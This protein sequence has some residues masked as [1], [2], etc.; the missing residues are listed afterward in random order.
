MISRL[1]DALN[2]IG[3]NPDGEEIADILWLALQMRISEPDRVHQD[4]VNQPDSQEA[5]S[6]DNL[7]SDSEIV[8]PQPQFPKRTPAPVKKTT[9]SAPLYTN[10][11]GAEQGSLTFKTPSAPSLQEPLQLGKALRPLMR[12]V[13]S[14]TETV[15]DE[16]ATAERI[17]EEKILVPVLKPARERWLDLALIADESPSMGIWRR[18]VFE[19]QR[20]LERHGAFR[21]VQ[22]WGLLTTEKGQIRLRSGIGAAARSRRLHSPNELVDPIGQRLFL[23]VSDC[24]S[25]MWRDGTVTEALIPWVKSGPLAI[26]QML[27]EQL[28]ERTALGLSAAVQLRSLNPGTPNQKLIAEGIDSWDVVDLESGLKVPVVTL[29]PESLSRWAQM[30]VGAGGA[31]TAGF[32]I[33]LPPTVGSKN[34]IAQEEQSAPTLS[35]EQRVHRFLNAASPV[36]R[37]LAG[38]LAA[39]PVISLPILRLIQ[40]TMLQQSRQVHIAEVFLGGILKPESSIDIHT[41]PDYVQY[42]FVDEK[43]RSILLDASPLSSSTKVLHEVSDFVAKRAGLSLQEFMA[44]LQDPTL[45]R[46]EAI[47][48]RV[49]PFA[50]VTAQVLKRLGGEYI[51]VAERLEQ[52]FDKPQEV[53]DVESAP[54]LYALLIGIDYYLPNKLP[55][56]VSYQSLRGCVRDINQVETFLRSQLGVSEECILKLTSSNTDGS[57]QPPEPPECWPTYENMV[58]AFKQLTEMAQPG[59]RVYIHYSGHGGR[60]VTLYPHLKGEGGMDTAFVPVDIAA[61]QGGYFRDI[62]F[63]FILKKMVNKGL[64]VTVVVDC[65][66]AGG[67]VGGDSDVRTIEIALHPTQSL[68]AANDELAANRINLTQERIDSSQAPASRNY[69][70]LAACRPDEQ[71]YEYAF[72]GDERNGVLTY[73][74]LDSLRAMGL[75]IT[76]KQLYDR[77][78]AKVHSQFPS[79]TPQLFGEGDRIVFGSDRIS[80]QDTVT[81]MQVDEK[82]KQVTLNAGRAQGLSSGTRFA[83]YPLNTTNFSNKQLQLAIIEVTDF[84]SSGAVARVLEEVDGGIGVKGQIE[85][86]APAV[87]LSAPVDLARRVRLF[88]RKK[89]GDAEN[90][91]PTQQLVNQQKDA[92]DKVRQALAENGW[93]VEVQGEEEAYYQVAISQQGEYEICIGMP[94]KNLNPPLS[95]GDPKAPKEVVKRLVH[96]AK[97][98]AV[99]ELDNPDSE[100]KDRLEF[101]LLDEKKQPLPDQSNITLKQ[102]TL[103]FLRVQNNSSR[104]LNVAVLDLEPTWAISQIP[105]G[106]MDAAFNQLTPYE[107]VDT[108]LRCQLPEGKE[109][110]RAMEVLKLFATIEPADFGW[111]ILPSLDKDSL[112]NELE[113][114]H[115]ATRGIQSTFSKLLEAG[116]EVP[117]VP[118]SLKRS[119]LKRSAVYTPDPNAEWVTKQIVITGSAFL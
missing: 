57:N 5:S 68:V 33:E 34:N 74:F 44:I 24:V 40:R 9:P 81:V 7:D 16:V 3:L 69:V 53:V 31:K 83:I 54:Q 86:G 80:I 84:E 94:I 106:G 25:S 82:Q 26:V 111:L 13:Q 23:V 76:Y 98:Q 61:P 93:V 4:Q 28:W 12:R 108:K 64:I 67:M 99:Q 46:T 19:L 89:L 56:G 118:P 47:S 41:D 60:T 66:Y 18:T 6:S 73:W 30:V 37:S 90:E 36:A 55:D 101:V 42:G 70:I 79:Q 85:Q 48:D 65:P 92:L 72:K 14:R 50:L 75:G 62:E 95:I 114:H 116:G 32:I 38:L 17:A 63:E 112:D 71:A 49:R 91:L 96:L 117:N 51:H 115:E 52:K 58:A 103:V 45:P 59:D 35:A 43:I 88:D 15:L 20:L 2:K 77:I 109:Y 39:A 27:P 110:D 105:L 104:T 107:T 100:L 29:E 8:P 78:F 119:S 102:D 11:I 97:Y 1:L 113:G 22:T 21:N 10:N 87:I